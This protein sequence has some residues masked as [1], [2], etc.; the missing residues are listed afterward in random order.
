MYRLYHRD[1]KYQRAMNNVSSNYK[2]K[3]TA[4]FL[5]S[6]LRLLVTANVVHCSLILSTLMMQVIC[7]LD[8]SVLTRA[9]RRNNPEDGVL[10]SDG[11][12]NGMGD[13]STAAHESL[14]CQVANAI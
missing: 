1:E 11:R 9:T 6:L 7:F 10:H 13:F 4:V 2:L 14:S 12:E 5:R 8:T 3:H